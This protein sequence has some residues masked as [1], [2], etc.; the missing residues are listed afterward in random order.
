MPER[1]YEMAS[2]GLAPRTVRHCWEAFYRLYR[3][4][5][6]DAGNSHFFMEYEGETKAALRI[7]LPGETVRRWLAML[8]ARDYLMDNRFMPVEIRR[9]RIAPNREGGLL[10][11]I[12]ASDPNQ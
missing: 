3:M 1:S 2:C 10:A 12:M 7:L 11:A 4:A 5:K 8:S 9:H 6:R